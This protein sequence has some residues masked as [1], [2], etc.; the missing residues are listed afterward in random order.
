MFLTTL[1]DSA[2]WTPC[3]SLILLLTRKHE[4]RQVE[5]KTMSGTNNLLFTHVP[6]YQRAEWV[7]RG[8]QDGSH[9]ATVVSAAF[10]GRRRQHGDRTA[11]DVYASI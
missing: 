9:S 5:Y 4:R 2:A 7:K 11:M 8:N 3:S 10:A 6:H 1:I